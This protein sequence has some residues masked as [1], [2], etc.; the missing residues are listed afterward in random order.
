MGTWIDQWRRVRDAVTVRR[1]ATTIVIGLILSGA[2][3]L[4]GVDWAA[5]RKAEPPDDPELIDNSLVTLRS[6]A[7]GGCDAIKETPSFTWSQF[8]N[9]RI[10]ANCIPGRFRISGFRNTNPEL[11]RASLGLRIIRKSSVGGGRSEASFVLSGAKVDRN[12]KMSWTG[13]VW[14]P[15]VPGTYRVCVVMQTTSGRVASR[16]RIMFEPMVIGTFNLHVL[17][18]VA[19]DS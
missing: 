12:N 3:R 7:I 2:Y 15:H 16:E 4:T 10:E 5:Y 17:P 8:V 19:R 11:L 18:E 1:S 14:I 9:V 6:V 13:K